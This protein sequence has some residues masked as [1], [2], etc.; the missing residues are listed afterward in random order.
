MFMGVAILGRDPRLSQGSS[1][2]TSIGSS[3][4][5]TGCERP[6]AEPSL[7]PWRTRRTVRV[8]VGD[9]GDLMAREAHTTA[10]ELSGSIARGEDESEIRA[11]R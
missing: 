10:K 9:A 1:Q 6:V 5:G 11:L 7:R 4:F 2:K 3:R 8:K